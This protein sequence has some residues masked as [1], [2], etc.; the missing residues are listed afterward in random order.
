ME[1]ESL[2]L[3]AQPRR[4]KIVIHKK[5]KR[6][7]CLKMDRIVILSLMLVC[8]TRVN[9]ILPGLIEI[10]DLRTLTVLLSVLVGYFLGK[11]YS[12]LRDFSHELDEPKKPE[13]T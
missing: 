11:T 10:G 7:I 5:A 2:F 13:P 6:L 12:R 1:L 9:Y 8:A 4:L 3:I